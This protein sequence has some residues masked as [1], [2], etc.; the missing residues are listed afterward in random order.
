KHR[1]SVFDG[2]GE[3]EERA[4][5]PACD[6]VREERVRFLQRALDRARYFRA[7]LSRGG[8]QESPV[9]VNVFGSD[10][11]PTLQRAVVK[12]TGA[13]PVTLFDD[14]ETRD[15][16]ARKLERLILAP[17]DG[18]VTATS[19]LGVPA[20]EANRARLAS[21]F[22]VCET[23]GLLPSNAS[24]QDNLFHVLL[25]GPAPSAVVPAVRA[26]GSERP[27]S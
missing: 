11:V 23:H 1:W 24:F 4:G 21:S 13:G 19:L 16:S 6:R 12:E 5:T 17:G 20:A 18:T 22:F 25:Q 15:R 26:E 2:R 27:G 10:C 7:A 8:A 14:E 9:P 3:A